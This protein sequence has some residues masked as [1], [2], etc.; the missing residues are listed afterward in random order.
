MSSPIGPILVV[1]DDPDSR[2]M[3]A[4]ALEFEGHTVTTAESGLQ[5]LRVAQQHRP[6]LILL[7]LMMPVMDGEEFRRQ[8]LKIRSIRKIPIV[9]VSARHDA[10]QIAGK[11]KAVGCIGKPVDFDALSV[12]I[13]RI[14]QGRSSLAAAAAW[15]RGR[16]EA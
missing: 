4:I 1:D 6:S 14:T 8:Q 2:T 9:V 16:R 15:L 10:S 11:L 13:R 7:D 3:L 5:A 12:L